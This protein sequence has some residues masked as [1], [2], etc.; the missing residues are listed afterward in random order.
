MESDRVA[1]T[2]MSTGLP[3]FRAHRNPSTAPVVLGVKTVERETGTVMDDITLSRVVS[4]LSSWNGMIYDMT[5]GSAA[6]FRLQDW[7]LELG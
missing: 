4:G 3:V 1:C 7:W 2:S 5:L 6:D